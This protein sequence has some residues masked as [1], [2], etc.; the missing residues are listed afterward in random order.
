M[1][2][3]YSVGRPSLET[4]ISD[5]GMG[6][7]KLWKV[8]YTVTSGPATGVKGHVMVPVEQYNA[9]NVHMA[10]ATAVNFHQ[11]VMGR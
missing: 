3:D 7:S 2:K 5:D 1:A 6:F 9:N 10:I 8:P 11:D 4:E